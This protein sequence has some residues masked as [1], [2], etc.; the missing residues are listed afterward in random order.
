MDI[1]EYAEKVF[2]IELLEYQKI[3]LRKLSLLP[4][5]S[6]LIYGV[7]GRIHVVPKDHIIN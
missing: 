7:D 4:K 2:G 5:D 3:L 6:R 1:V